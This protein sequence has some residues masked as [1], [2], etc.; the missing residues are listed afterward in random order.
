MY[1]PLKLKILVDERLGQGRSVIVN[2][3][4]AQINLPVVER[5][6]IELLVH[7]LEK[8][9]ITHIQRSELRRAIVGKIK[10]QVEIR[11]RAR[12]FRDRHLMIAILGIAPRRAVHRSLRQPCLHRQYRLGFGSGRFRFVAGE[13]EHLLHVLHIL[14][15]RLHRLRIILYVVIAIRQRD[16]SLIEKRNRLGRIVHV[17]LRIESKQR[18]SADSRCM[19]A[20]CES[21]LFSS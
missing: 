7:L 11:S 10:S 15:P 16:A 21:D 2:R 17:G 6:V 19:Y 5:N 13:L 1:L 14:L 8:I 3:F 4:P 18:R 20:I 12:D 9:R